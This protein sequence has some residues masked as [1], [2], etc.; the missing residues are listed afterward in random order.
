MYRG[1]VETTGVSVAENATP[2]RDDY[3]WARDQSA[4]T[5][6]KSVA[7]W[8]SKRPFLQHT[9][10]VPT[11]V[12]GLPA[13]RVSGQLKPGARLLAHKNDAPVAPTF[14]DDGGQM[15]YSPSL[16]GEYTL[17]D[18]PGAGLT[19]I[20]SWSLDHGPKALAGNQAFIDRLAFH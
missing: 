13:W 17:V 2:V 4:G 14:I 20:W 7:T 19:V 9:A 11:Q 3:S 6:A 8:L 5:S 15:A 18:V 12:G 10:V 1:D 16:I